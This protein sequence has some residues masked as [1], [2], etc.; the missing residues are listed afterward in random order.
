MKETSMWKKQSPS[1]EALRARIE[2]LPVIET[3]EHWSGICPA[4]DRLD[5][6][7]WLADASYYQSDLGSAS[8]DF[9]DRI[10][11]QGFAMSP[12]TEFMAD[13][14]H[15]FD[16][17]YDAWRTHHDR[18]CHT[19]YA[20]S[21]FE[22]L[23]ACWGLKSVEKADLLALQERMRAE[24]NQAYSD[25][26]LAQH[27]IQ[28]MVVNAITPFPDI[29][30]GR[31]PYRKGFARF[32]MD[33]PQYHEIFGEASIRKPHLEAALGRRIVTLDDYLEAFELFLKQAIAFGIVGLKDQTAYR[34]ALDF[35]NPPRARAEEIFNRIIARP[36][37]TFGT[38][39]V[40]DLDD[41]LFNRFLRL[42]ARHRLPVQVHT[43]HMAGLRNEILKAS[44]ALLTPMLELHA[45]V[46]FD[47]FHGGWPFMGEFLFLGKNYPNVSLDL[48]WVN[49][50]D[51]LYSVELLQR[52]V[53]TVPHSKIMG[54]GGDT[55]LFETQVGGLIL[56]RD[57]IAIAL[58][59][60]VDSGWLG[61][62]EAE[63][64]ARAWLFDNPGRMFGGE[65][66]AR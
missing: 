52:G 49:T 16:A 42:A 38:A 8:G 59:G 23:R 66:A 48:C 45:D 34:R 17:R 2:A 19:A 51:P 47:L 10:P 57:N 3:H 29:V 53:M 55:H 43:G 25:R 18:T 62:D 56:A 6:L 21:V 32:V 46:A 40:R 1:H 58:A 4:N 11:R 61:L 30:A 13:T 28:G 15:A 22:G 14:R 27:G 24:R 20:R 63:A 7:A 35:G 54:Y 41:F 44:P 65:G 39:E 5:V 64:V 50:I 37:D 12:L 60:L 36:R 26:M 31:T 9:G 33:L